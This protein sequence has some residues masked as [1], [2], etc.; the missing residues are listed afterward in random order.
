VWCELRIH[1]LSVEDLAVLCVSVVDGC[2][3]PVD[4]RPEVGDVL[5]TGWGVEDGEVCECA[6]QA[7]VGEVLQSGVGVSTL[8]IAN[9]FTALE[10]NSPAVV[11]L[12]VVGMLLQKGGW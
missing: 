10:N 12:E 11:V 1:P 8:C 3:L 4:H 6:S 7:R 5:G 9:R 2:S